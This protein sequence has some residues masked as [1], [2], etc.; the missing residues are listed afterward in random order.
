M[1]HPDEH[2]LLAYADGERNP[3]IEEH[4]ASCADCAEHVRLL[5]AG[6]DALRAAPL[7]ELPAERRREMIAEL[8]DREPRW[9]GL[10]ARRGPALAAAAALVLVAGI[11]ALG[12]LS[13]G[14]QDDEGAA[15][16]GEAERSAASPEDGAAGG[17]GELTPSMLDEALGEP[18]RTVS[19]PVEAVLRALQRE[20]IPAVRRD[21]SVVAVADEQEI[22]SVLAQ[23]PK[24]N[25]RVFARPP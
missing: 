24:G 11:V 15:G 8:P 6:R 7:L 17:G 22:R 5:E 1:M 3:E 20:G 23:R 10:R 12:T 25:V 14:G 18:V 2:L 16:A 21:G 13:G 4:V 9:A 19:G